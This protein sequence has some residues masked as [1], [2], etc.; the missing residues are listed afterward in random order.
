MPQSNEVLEKVKEIIESQPKRQRICVLCGYDIPEAVEEHHIIYEP[1]I[2]VML[3]ANCHR[4]VTRL[5]RRQGFY[6]YERCRGLVLRYREM[7]DI[8]WEEFRGSK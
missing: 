4:I 3:C 7:R 8:I 1:P 6:D 5:D 2:T